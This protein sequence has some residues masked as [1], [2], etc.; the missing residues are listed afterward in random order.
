MGTNLPLISII[1]TSCNY[2]EFV[3]QAIESVLNQTYKNIEVIVIDDGSK[4]NSRTVIEKYVRRYPKIIFI[5]QKN[6]GV[7][8]TRNKGME[9]AKGDFLCC[10]DADD[11]FDKDYIEKQYAYMVDYEADVVYPNWNLIGDVNQKVHFQEFD[12]I[13]YQKQHLHIKPESLIRVSKIKDRNGKLILGYLEETKER[14]ND[15]AY[16]ITLAANG[17]KFKLAEENYVN[18]RI[19]PGSMGSKFDK[20]DEVKIFHSYLIMLKERYGEKIIDPIELP[21]DMIKLRD[22]KIAELEVDI[23]SKEREFGTN[24]KQLNEQLVKYEST[25]TNMQRSLSWKATRPLRLVIS[26]LS[27]RRANTKF[28][29]S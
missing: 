14:A 9:L 10:L 4:D 27:N 18:Y 26:K 25:I 22:Q 12:F 1:I 29:K 23:V 11:Y 28:K 21:I 13:E 6:H 17:L 16:F 3:A 5:S 15:W 20:Y 2:A 7:V 24:I 8:F 19:K